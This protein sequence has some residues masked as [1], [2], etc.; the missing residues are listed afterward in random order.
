L[1]ALAGAVGGGDPVFFKSNGDLRGIKRDL[2]EG[3]FACRCSR[4]GSARF[5]RG[6]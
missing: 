5:R 4:A 1:A 3:A 6:A 2:Y